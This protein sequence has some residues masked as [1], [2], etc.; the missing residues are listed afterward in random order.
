M[1]ESNDV[2]E[3]YIFFRRTVSKAYMQMAASR[4]EGAGKTS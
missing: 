4:A 1:T 2:S 3:E